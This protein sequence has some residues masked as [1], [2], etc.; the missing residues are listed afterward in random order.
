MRNIRCVVDFKVQHSFRCTAKCRCRRRI[1]LAGESWIPP[2]LTRLYRIVGHLVMMVTT[3]I[4][5]FH[6]IWLRQWVD[7]SGWIKSDGGNNPEN[8]YRSFEQL[9][10]LLLLALAFV[11]LLDQWKNEAT[12]NS[13]SALTTGNQPTTTNRVPPTATNGVLPTATSGAPSSA[14]NGAPDVNESCSCRIAA[15]FSARSPTSSKPYWNLACAASS[16]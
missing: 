8:E 7:S 12:V 11:P 2:W 5:W 10:P 3:G 4:I 9:A 13:N 6:I 16:R 14:T 1:L 15:Y